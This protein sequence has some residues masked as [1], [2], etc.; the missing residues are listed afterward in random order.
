LPDTEKTLLLTVVLP[1]TTLELE[2][3]LYEYGPIM[4]DKPPPKTFAPLI[5][6]PDN[7]AELQRA[8]TLHEIAKATA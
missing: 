5:D 7:D 2:P 3:K 1:E 6:C 8:T 4:T